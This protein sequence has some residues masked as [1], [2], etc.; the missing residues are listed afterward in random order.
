MSCVSE[1]FSACKR[2]ARLLQLLGDG[3]AQPLARFGEMAAEPVALLREAVV[4]IDQHAAMLVRQRFGQALGK[5]AHRARLRCAA[6]NQEREQDDRNEGEKG[7]EK[8]R[9]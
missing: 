1:S 8:T 7:E 4:Q 5:L 6:C 3:A 2:V 9:A